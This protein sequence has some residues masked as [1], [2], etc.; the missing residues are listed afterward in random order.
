MRLK[1]LGMT[2]YRVGNEVVENNT[3]T[4]HLEKIKTKTYEKNNRV[5]FAD[6]S[7]SILCESTTRLQLQETF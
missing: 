2:V 6:R 7:I 5:L 3:T 1:L 4:K